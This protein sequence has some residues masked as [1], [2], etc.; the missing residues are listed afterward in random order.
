MKQ[1]TH[2]SILSKKSNSLPLWF[3]ISF[4]ISLILIAVFGDYIFQ[5][6]PI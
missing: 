4:I 5:G 3:Y 1:K 2:H 6:V